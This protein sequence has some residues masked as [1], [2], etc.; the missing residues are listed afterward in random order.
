MRPLA[1]NSTHRH[2]AHP[3]GPHVVGVWDSHRL[4]FVTILALVPPVAI[5]LAQRPTEIAWAALLALVV[6]LGWHLLFALSRRRAF[7]WYGIVTALSFVVL[8]PANTPFWHQIIAL[9]FGVVMGEQIFGG[10]GRN[11]LNPTAV[12]LAFLYFSFHEKFVAPQQIEL[13]LATIPGGLLLLF[14]RIISWRALMGSAIGF[15]TGIIVAGATFSPDDTLTGS[16]MFGLF[17]LA[18]DPVSTASTNT[19]RWVY[20]MLTGIL[21]VIIGLAG[22]GPG[23]TQALVFATLLGSVFAPLIDYGVIAAH[24]RFRERRYE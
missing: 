17:F 4:A 3:T 9:T 20:G 6:S 18:C 2:F 22:S 1:K 10:R 12:A 15:L 14:T 16:L 8:L 19:G 13:L 23:S 5:V 21:I 7:N 24:A 11:F